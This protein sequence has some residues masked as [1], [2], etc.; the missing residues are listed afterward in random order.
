VLDRAE[1]IRA[2]YRC[3]RPSC[4]C[5]SGP[6]VHCP[7]H[8]DKKPSFG[9]NDDPAKPGRVL[10]VCRSGCDQAAV[11]AKIKE[12][13]FSLD[14]GP[15]NVVDLNTRRTVQQQPGETLI[16]IYDYT[17]ED[18]KPLYQKARF[19]FGPKNQLTG[20]R[21]KRF[22]WR[23]AGESGWKGLG[24][25]KTEDIPLYQPVKVKQWIAAK[26]PI[27]FVEGEK[28]VAA[29]EAAGLAATCG[30]WS[31]SAKDFG[32]A[33]RILDGADVI[34]WP[35]ND[36]TGRTY[37]R[38]IEIALK[39]IAK[40]IRWCTP[41]LA[42]KG[43]AAD[44]FADGGVVQDLE[45]QTPPSGPVVDRIS[46]D[47]I[48]VR[49]PSVFGVVE[50]EFSDMERT[51]RSLEAEMTIR[52]PSRKDD[53]S[54]RINVMSFSAR[55][56]LRRDLDTM[57][58]T[59][60]TWAEIL[61]GAFALARQAYLGHDRS[62]RLNDIE[63]VQE[64]GFLIDTLLVDGQ[65]NVIFA[66]G[67]SGKTFI[68]MLMAVCVAGGL[69]CLGYK[70][71]QGPVLFIDYENNEQTFRYRMDRVIS[72]LRESGIQVPNDLPIS[73]WRSRGI[74]LPEQADAIRRKCEKD[75][76]RMLAVD[77][78]AAACGGEPENA[79]IAL[80]YFT[81]GLD[82]V[83]DGVT[84]VTIAH[85]PKGGDTSQPFG[86]A[87]WKNQPRRTWYVERDQRTDSDEIAIVLHCKKVNDGPLPGAIA[88]AIRFGAAGGPVTFKREEPRVTSFTSSTE[89]ASMIWRCLNKP[90][91]VKDIAELM[92]AQSETIRKVLNDPRNRHM[93]QQV[94]G[95]AGGGRGK[96]ALWQR[97][98]KAEPQDPKVVRDDR[99][100]WGESPDGPAEPAPAPQPDLFGP[101][102]TGT[103]D[104]VP[105]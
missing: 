66:D 62:V 32:S 81:A 35:D 28:A 86:S 24:G 47:H 5:S 102:A 30:A 82:K 10:V 91:T 96:S 73:Y 85:V 84:T 100:Q 60:D 83:G 57:T 29:L 41:G 79:N 3:G 4:P 80:R 48:I 68:V 69:P 67:S 37:M 56:D 42:E 1:Q 101:K 31:G 38:R 2:A 13:G 76:I 55:N 11:V 20:K 43:D 93:F 39:P 61:L 52:I 7:V 18:G 25:A 6:N 59:K 92:S 16:A 104:D 75:G 78:A 74:P 45:R 58:A 65:H 44:F 50:F 19:E 26:Q 64:L 77:S 94:E 88:L 46:H 105:F 70:V 51:N 9:V 98:D 15:E 34:L 72:G 36:E 89:L 22:T 63:P 54:Q 33:L 17:T 49:W 87:F 23:I 95:T 103:D 14:P 21:E 71:K 53:I 12:D 40:S 8:T 27:Y 99:F 97:V 90:R